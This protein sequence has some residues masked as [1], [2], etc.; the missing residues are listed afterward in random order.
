MIYVAGPK[1]DG[2][3]ANRNLVLSPTA[4]ADPFLAWKF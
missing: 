1:T 3:Q 2:Y 4:R